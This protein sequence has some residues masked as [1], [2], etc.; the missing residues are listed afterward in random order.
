[1]NLNIEA[2]KSEKLVLGFF[3]IILFSLV[4]GYAVQQS[5]PPGEIQGAGTLEASQIN[6]AESTSFYLD[7]SDTS[8][9]KN[10][11]IDSSGSLDLKNNKI[12]N[13]AE[14]STST[15]AATKGYVDSNSGGSCNLLISR[16]LGTG[17]DQTYTTV[18]VPSECETATGCELKYKVN[19]YDGGRS[20]RVAKYWLWGQ[21]QQDSDGWWSGINSYK[22]GGSGDTD[23]V[24]VFSGGVNGDSNEDRIFEVD[25]GGGYGQIQADTWL[26]DDTSQSGGEEN[27]NQW[28]LYY[29]TDSDREMDLYLYHC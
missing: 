24:D 13:V 11:V 2:P 15:D 7:P 20:N 17:V 26:R 21:V 28:S 19:I 29:R 6:D 9:L 14:P 10:L 18:S 1:M 4:I 5:H 3:F 16:S 23:K 27:M 8:V 12:I 22:L 25:T